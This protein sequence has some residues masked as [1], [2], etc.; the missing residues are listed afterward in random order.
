[1]TARHAAAGI[2]IALVVSMVIGAVLAASRFLEQAAQPILMLVLVA[3]WVAY[4][5]LDR[6]VA[7]AAAIRR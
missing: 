3:P 5:T 4:F 1:M 6:R 7:R 2:V